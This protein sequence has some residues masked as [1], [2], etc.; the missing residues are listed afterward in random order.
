LNTTSALAALALLLSPA[1]QAAKVQTTGNLAFGRFVAASGGAVTVSQSGL[2]SRSGAVVLLASSAAPATFSI[3]DNTPGNGRKL[4]IVTLPANGS[5][6][7]AN[8]AQ[9]MPVDGFVSNAPADGVLGPPPGL[10]QV[11]ATLG[12]AASQAPGSYSG[13]FQITVEYQ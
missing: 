4:L 13:S 2:R 8:G 7:L 3:S 6:F 9:R 1:V 11:G 10:L 5:V 12:V